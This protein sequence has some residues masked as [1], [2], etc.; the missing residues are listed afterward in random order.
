MSM[1]SGAFKEAEDIVVD[2][3]LFG[4]EEE[5]NRHL[6]QGHRFRKIERNSECWMNLLEPGTREYIGSLGR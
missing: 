4:E 2:N 5:R 1:G 3:D 6:N